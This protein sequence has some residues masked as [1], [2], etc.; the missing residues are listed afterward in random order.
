M[1]L[2]ESD[3]TQACPLCA[4]SSKPAFTGRDQ[5]MGLPGEFRY[6]ECCQCGAV[7]Q[8]PLPDAQAIASYY[9]DSY[10]G[11]DQLPVSKAFG[12]LRR[13]VLASRYGYSV[14]AASGIQLLIGRIAATI[15]Y[16]DEIPLQDGGA[17]LDV[18]CGNGKFVQK[19]N[20]LGWQA[21]GVEFS[22]SAAEAGIEA[23]LEITVGTLEDAQFEDGSF[24]L[25]TAR[26]LIEHL[27]DPKQFMAEIRRL[28]RPGGRLLIRTPNS[29]ALGRRWFGANWYANDPP[30]H[31]IMFTPAN[32]GQLAEQ[33]G[34]VQVTSKTFTSPK[35]VLN[36]WDYRTGNKDKP[37]RKKGLMRAIVRIYVA[38]AALT[39]RGDEIFAVYERR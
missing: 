9:P 31:L 11:H 30:R 20:A 22:K 25:I 15:F 21:Q 29:N 26:H 8:S 35:I 38:I 28:F 19:L 39:G 14:F 33:A 6:L 2:A 12:W 32:L 27:P 7:Y 34:L 36:S 18:G 37:S 1:A 17:A 24:S 23:G 10:L 5:L 16:R 4:G 13:A 3:V